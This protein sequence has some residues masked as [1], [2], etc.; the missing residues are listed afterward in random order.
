MSEASVEPR[1]VIERINAAWRA[2]RANDSAPLFHADAIILAPNGERVVGREAVIRSY[3]EFTAA[4]AIDEYT[5]SDY[6]VDV[7]GATAVVAYR[8]Q[9]AW[10]AGGESY[11]ERGRDVFVL[12]RGAAGWQVAWRTLLS[13]GDQPG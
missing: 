10:R 2:G 9:M 4:A 3:V 11:R 12:T 8:W 5:E 13:D 6:T 1:A 7:F